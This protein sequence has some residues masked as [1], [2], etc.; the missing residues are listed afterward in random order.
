[1][2]IHTLE[3][4]KELTHNELKEIR[5][6]LKNKS[7]SVISKSKIEI[8][9][10]SNCGI[11]I[12]LMDH[13]HY[14]CIRFVINPTEV[15]DNGNV[16][17]IFGDPDKLSDVVRLFDK[18]IFGLFGSR[19]SF[20]NLKLTR[21][22]LCT[23]LQ[24][25]SRKEVHGYIELLYKSKM[26]KG[27]K[28]KGRKCENYD[29]EIGFACDNPTA[30]ISIS[31]YDKEAQLLNI[32]KPKAAKNVGNRLRVEVQLRSQ[33]SLHKYCEYESNFERICYFLDYGRTLAVKILNDLLIDADYYTLPK[34]IEIVCEHESGKFRDRMVRLLKLTSKHHSVRLAV[35]ALKSGGPIV[36]DKYIKKILREFH[37]INVNVVTLGRRSELKSLGSLLA[38]I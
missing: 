26:K 8:E 37:S 22:D 5:N 32:E 35:K 9:K 19:F 24:L 23:D 29:T 30:G 6:S 27:Y 34:A 36:D 10:Y 3:L 14:P 31:I 21:V 38:Q 18:Y 17:D 33:K 7:L 11:R 4:T 16:T 25:S 13:K 2:A 20:E 15:L 28:I 12:Y 1:M